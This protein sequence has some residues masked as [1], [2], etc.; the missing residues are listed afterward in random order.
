MR[1]LAFR[2][3]PFEH[4][5]LIVPALGAHGVAFEYVDLFRDASIPLDLDSAAGLIFMGGPMSVNDNLPFLE[6]E[7]RLIERAVAAGKPVLG[8]CLG[9]QLIA[10]A[11]G[12]RVYRNEAKEI[13]WFPVHFTK[14]CAGD[15]L[16]D[17]FNGPETVF[18][19]HGETFDLPE[20]ARLLASS[21]AC[22][23]QAFRWG[24]N[25]YGIQFHLEV[26]PEMIGDWLTEDENCSDVRELTVRP[27]PFYNG[28]RLEEL[29]RAVFGR[30]AGL[31]KT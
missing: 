27:D 12:A 8:V 3:V 15:S 10:R 30:W 26:T 1:V 18:H 31:C 22:R 16:F 7:L 23:N 28:A 14:E 17:G 19:W 11:L 5:G 25:V 6:A 13:G 20:G 24:R 2:H 9:A 4:L 21:D 29:S